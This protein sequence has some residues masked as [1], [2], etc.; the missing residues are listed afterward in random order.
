MSGSPRVPA[1]LR[2][3]LSVISASFMVLSANTCHL[4]LLILIWLDLQSLSSVLSRH[5]GLF[6][7]VVAPH[8]SRTIHARQT[9]RQH[10]FR[11]LF[12]LPASAENHAGGLL[13]CHR[14][15]S[16]QN[17][18]LV[19]SSHNV[20]TLSRGVTPLNLTRQWLTPHLCLCPLSRYLH[21]LPP[22]RYLFLVLLNPLLLLLNHS[23]SGVGRRCLLP[24]HSILPSVRMRSIRASLLLFL[25]H[26]Q[27][28]RPISG[29]LHRL[30]DSTPILA[31]SVT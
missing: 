20:S 6:L 11:L 28:I 25:A 5:L 1:F 30:R 23:P 24:L 17:L 8:T 9:A 7:F 10:I 18:L 2:H 29:S 31:P 15:I 13:V 16:V 14:A 12:R 19:A 22:L 21:L 4:L 3:I 26:H 27:R